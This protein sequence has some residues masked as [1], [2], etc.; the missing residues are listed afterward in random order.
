MNVPAFL[1]IHLMLSHHRITTHPTASTTTAT[2]SAATTR[3]MASLYPP[4]H[5]ATTMKLEA[6]NLDPAVDRLSPLAN[7]GPR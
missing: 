6:L 3:P 7:A 1:R 2:A 4:T 5:S